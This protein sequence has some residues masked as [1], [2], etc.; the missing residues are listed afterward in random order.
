VATLAN[1]LPSPIERCDDLVAFAEYKQ[2]MFSAI[3]QLP[4]KEKQVMIR[5]RPVVAV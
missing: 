1:V 4:E 5:K 3:E 2:A